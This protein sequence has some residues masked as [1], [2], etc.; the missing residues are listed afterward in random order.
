MNDIQETTAD[1][2][3]NQNGQLITIQEIE[4]LKAESLQYMR[5]DKQASDKLTKEIGSHLAALDKLLA[6]VQMHRIAVPAR[7]RQSLDEAVEQ[8]S[9][10]AYSTR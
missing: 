4:T 1:R 3:E 5:R 7:Y 9:Q 2:D 8:A 6:L 10:T